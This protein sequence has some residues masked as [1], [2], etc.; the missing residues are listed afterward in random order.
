MCVETYIQSVQAPLGF[1]GELM[2]EILKPI[3]QYYVLAIQEAM[4][5]KAG[6]LLAVGCFSILEGGLR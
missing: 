3:K 2:K 1:Y 4:L 5:P 6:P